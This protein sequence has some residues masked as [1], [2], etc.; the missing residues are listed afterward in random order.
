[1]DQINEHWKQV[2]EPAPVGNTFEIYEGGGTVIN[3]NSL[4]EKEPFFMQHIKQHGIEQEGTEEQKEWLMAEDKDLAMYNHVQKIKEDWKVQE[5][6]T[7]KY[8]V[9]QIDLEMKNTLKWL[10]SKDQ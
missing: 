4:V 6:D 8:G 9:K 10:E 7:P 1:M 3:R 2:H 5:D